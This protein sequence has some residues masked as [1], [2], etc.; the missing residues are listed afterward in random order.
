MSQNSAQSVKNFGQS[1]WYDNI[2][3]DLIESG[4]LR[5]LINEWGVRGVT[6]NPA[7]FNK[8]I[9]G[10]NTYSDS[11]L[12]LKKQGLSA[13]KIFESI[14]VADIAEAADILLP[15]YEESGGE[16][17]FVS[18]EVSPLL[19]TDTEGSISEAKRLYEKLARPNIMIKIPGTK[20]GVPAIKAL[21][22]EGININV[23]LLFSVE[24][25]VEVAN[26]YVEALSERAQKNLPIDKIRSVASF[27]VSRVDSAVD[28]YLDTLN[29]SES[30]LGQVQSKFGIANS[31]LAYIEFQKI[32]STEKFKS[33]ESKGAKVQRPLWASTSTKNKTLSDVLYVESL[34]GPDTVNTIPHATLEAFVDHGNAGSTLEID[35][36]SAKEVKEKLEKLDVPIEGILEK[37][38][39]EG[40]QQFVDSFVELNQTI[41][42]A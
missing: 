21:L 36:N 25:Y 33:L 30:E 11:I 19:A 6:S 5:R 1:V 16:D 31:K 40:V 41:E 7:I 26:A 14:A 15:I 24:S 4:E 10:S 35:L 20:E 2:S 12:E 37:L 38:Q 17:G 22:L 42:S 3:R 13:D 9:G 23:T 8:A 27:F 34:I 29:L 32:F 39:V 18:I 28:S